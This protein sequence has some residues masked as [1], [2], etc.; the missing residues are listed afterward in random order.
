M[1]GK[2]TPDTEQPMTDAATTPGTDAQPILRVRELS[3][4]FPIYGKGFFRRQAGTVKAVERVSFDVMQG[5]TLGLVGESGSGK[6]TVARSILRALKPTQG[7]ILFRTGGETVNLATIS[8]RDLKPLR[9]QMQMIFQDPFSSLNPRMTAGEIVAEPL[10]I[11]D[12]ARGKALRQRVDEALRRVG[13]RPEHRSRYPHA[14]SGG[15]RQRIGIARALIVDPSLIIAD[16]AISALDVSVQ[17]QVLN[18]LM[19]IQRTLS[20]TYIFVTHDLGVV[21]HFCDRVAV[22]YGGRIVEFADTEAIF[23]QPRH[24]YTQAL[25]AAIPSPDPDVSFTSTLTGEAADPADLPPGCSFHPRCPYA[26]PGRCDV[27]GEPPPLRKLA[28]GRFAACVRAEEILEDH[29]GTA[30]AN[31]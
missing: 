20:L 9:L 15:Q 18:L 10:V 31:P 30:D 27:P 1:T 3:K 14:F 24:P 23:E 7:E 8:E 21:R 5:E 17:A 2:A 11:H 16:E 6:T 29:A 19:E 12:L 22:M 25:I 26:Q 13:L 4:H 28:P